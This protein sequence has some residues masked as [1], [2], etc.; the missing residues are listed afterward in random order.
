MH[1]L[2]TSAC[3][4]LS[5]RLSAVRD[6][7]IMKDRVTGGPRGFAFV[8]FFSAEDATRALEVSGGFRV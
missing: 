6:I 8:H 4:L 5:C 3:C 7:R 1:H 2:R